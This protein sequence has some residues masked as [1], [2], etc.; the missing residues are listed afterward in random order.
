MHRSTGDID[1]AS[2]GVYP[3]P[4][5]NAMDLVPKSQALLASHL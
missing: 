4:L 3:M 1:R 5:T 2:V